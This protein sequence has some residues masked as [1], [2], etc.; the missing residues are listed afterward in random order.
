MTDAQ[1]R[2]LQGLFNE[3]PAAFYAMPEDVL[4]AY[5]AKNQEYHRRTP[6]IRHSKEN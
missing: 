6:V 3:W 2:T 1:F 5:F 4:E